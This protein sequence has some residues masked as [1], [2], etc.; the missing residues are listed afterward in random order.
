ML[1]CLEKIDPNAFSSED[2]HSIIEIL[3]SIT[4]ELDSALSAYL[5]STRAEVAIVANLSGVDAEGFEEAKE[6]I[7]YLNSY[8]EDNDFRDIETGQREKRQENETQLNASDP[9]KL[10]IKGQVN[11]ILELGAEYEKLMS[12]ADISVL[13]KLSFF[14]TR[15]QYVPEFI[16]KHDEMKARITTLIDKYQPHGSYSQ[17]DPDLGDGI[18]SDGSVFQKGAELLLPFRWNFCRIP[19]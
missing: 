17:E 18:Q 4:L 15:S 8:I 5:I 6:T 3:N 11:K 14:K 13:R 1:D 16:R 9:K 10:D 19:F 12:L 7:R 2:I